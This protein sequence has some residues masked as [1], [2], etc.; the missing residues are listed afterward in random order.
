MTQPSFPQQVINQVFGSTDAVWTP[1][2]QSSYDEF[3][4]HAALQTVFAGA[5][6]YVIDHLVRVLRNGYLDTNQS[7]L[8]YHTKQHIHIALFILLHFFAC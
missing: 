3:D 7:R 2:L 4:L 8:Y 6:G 1:L 5:D